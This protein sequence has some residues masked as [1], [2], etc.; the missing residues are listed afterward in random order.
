M[1]K[2]R[3][4]REHGTGV[5]EKVLRYTCTSRDLYAGTESDGRI[6]HVGGCRVSGR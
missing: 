1:V 5:R 3:G 2:I 4:T 6:V